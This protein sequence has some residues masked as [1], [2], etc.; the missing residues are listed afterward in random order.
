MTDVYCFV[1]VDEH[2]QIEK[3]SRPLSKNPKDFDTRL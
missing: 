2:K 3:V 1:L